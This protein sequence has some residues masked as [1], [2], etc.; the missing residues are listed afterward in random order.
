MSDTDFDDGISVEEALA[1][2][3]TLDVTG[4]TVTVATK[5]LIRFI[6][7]EFE[8]GTYEATPPIDGAEVEGPEGLIWDVLDDLGIED[9]L[10]LLLPD[11]IEHIASERISH[12]LDAGEFENIDEELPAYVYAYASFLGE[13]MAVNMQTRIMYDVHSALDVMDQ[14]A[15]GKMPKL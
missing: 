13:A 5:E 6:E 11:L 14:I 3:P 1:R 7:D 2:I 12:K 15:S 10:Y 4:D 9:H 8:P